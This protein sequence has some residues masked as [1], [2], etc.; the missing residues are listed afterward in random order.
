MDNNIVSTVIVIL[1]VVLRYGF[2][3]HWIAKAAVNRGRSY[4]K[5]FFWGLLFSFWSY[6]V[7][8]CLS[9]I[10]KA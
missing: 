9:P 6:I 1:L 4:G 8:R 3:P 7:L 5:W 2:I 10:K